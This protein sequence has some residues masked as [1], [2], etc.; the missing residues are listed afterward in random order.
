MGLGASFVLNYQLRIGVEFVWNLTL[1]DHLDDVSNTYADPEAP[2][3]T[4]GSCCRSPSPA[5]RC[6]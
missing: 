1:T 3:T 2:Q 6:I 5:S 4:L